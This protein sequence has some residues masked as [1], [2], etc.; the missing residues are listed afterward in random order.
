MAKYIRYIHLKQLVMVR[1]TPDETKN[2]RL[3]DHEYFSRRG[4]REAIAYTLTPDT[5]NPGWEIVTYYGAA[6]VDP[7]NIP[8]SPHYIYILVNPSVPGICKIGFTTTTV[9]DRV[10]QIN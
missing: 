6:W 1:I 3:L 2:Y 10:K 4:M 9:Y 8:H 5:D 7:T